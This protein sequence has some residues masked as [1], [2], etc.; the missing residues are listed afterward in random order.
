MSRFGMYLLAMN[1]D[2]S[3]PQVAAAQ[4][5]F[6]VMTR[7]AETDNYDYRKVLQDLDDDTEVE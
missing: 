5:Y 2:P 1:G 7:A 3:K 4:Q 6:A